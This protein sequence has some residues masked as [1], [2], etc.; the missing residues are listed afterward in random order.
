MSAGCIS[1]GYRLQ[2]SS[3][4]QSQ[5]ACEGERLRDDPRLGRQCC[6]IV[7]PSVVLRQ[8]TGRSPQSPH[9]KNITSK[10]RLFRKAGLGARSAL[11][12]VILF[13]NVK[14][15][16]LNTDCDL[17]NLQWHVAF[18]D[19][20]MCTVQ[21]RTKGASV[22]VVVQELSHCAMQNKAHT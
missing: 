17:Q 19:L 9:H 7:R 12:G 3:R 4:T 5:A 11:V 8:H 16:N 15:T 20:F 1:F 22:V 13:L 14:R 21:I 10:R 6:P 18:F 2:K